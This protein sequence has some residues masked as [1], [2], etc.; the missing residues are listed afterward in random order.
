MKRLWLAIGI[1]ALVFCATLYNAHLLGDFSSGLADTL[2]R[3]EE[4][5]EAGEWR[6]A[7]ELTQKA[8]EAWEGHSLYLHVSLRHS[9]TDQIHTTFHEVLEYVEC[10]QDGEYSAANARLMAQLELL[11]E[12][13]QLTLENLF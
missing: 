6:Q 8:Y 10:R 2:A 5:A 9:D 7:G 3:A 1:M 12:S 4:H 11:N 13:E